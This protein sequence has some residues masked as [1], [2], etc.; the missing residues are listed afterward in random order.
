MMT[1]A[2]G[3]V[4]LVAAMVS[5]RRGFDDG[6]V[7]RDLDEGRKAWYHVASWPFSH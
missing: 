1:I 2:L 3:G 5:Y 4:V 6:W 7:H